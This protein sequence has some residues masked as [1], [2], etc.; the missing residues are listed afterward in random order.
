VLTQF[1]AEAEAPTDDVR[2]S[3][4]QIEKLPLSQKLHKGLR[5]DNRQIETAEYLSKTAAVP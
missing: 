1:S 2:D 3:T 5:A 4:N